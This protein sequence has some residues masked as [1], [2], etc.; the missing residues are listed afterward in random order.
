MSEENIRRRVVTSLR[1]AIDFEQQSN[2]VEAYRNYLEGLALVAAALQQDAD[3]CWTQGNPILTAKERKSLV[4]FA[5]QSVSRLVLLLDKQDQESSNVFKETSQ[6]TDNEGAMRSH[7]HDLPAVVTPVPS[8]QRGNAAR[9]EACGACEESPIAR[10]RHEN[11]LLVARY[12][13][14]LRAATTASQ[15]QNLQ[16]E[17][18]RRL[19]ENTAI[20]RQRQETWEQHRSE[21]A[22]RC[23]RLAESKFQIN[24]K[25]ESGTITEADFKKQRVYSAAL[26][27]EE[28]N[29]WFKKLKQDVLF[30][31][32]DERLQRDVIG[33]ILDRSHPVG[34]M[35][36]QMQYAVLD[37]VNPIITK[38]QS[39]LA[40][41]HRSETDYAL[42]EHKAFRRHFQNIAADIKRD[43]KLLETL[44]ITIVEPLGSDRGRGIIT[45][46]LHQVY[47]APVKHHLIILL[48]LVTHNDEVELEAAISGQAVDADAD[49]R[50]ACA[51]LRHLP[52][53][54]SPCHM[55]DSL[56]TTLKAL[57]S[58]SDE[59]N[60]CKS[61]GADDLLP[62]LTAVVILCRVPSLLAEA[63][64]MENFMPTERA[65]GEGGYAVTVLQSVMSCLLPHSG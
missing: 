4:G 23:H 60:H 13:T 40:Q 43:I 3:S 56:V 2:D 59:N 44:L 62:R 9:E 42:E 64:Y 19:S 14:R 27:F 8:P 21:V 52:S 12:S 65:L 22:A 31:P 57:A 53:L 34:A 18:E 36:C 41:R 61:L 37:K 58:T 5:E 1:K 30:Q 15:R 39:L 26:Q 45:E 33:R 63:T 6:V 29:S 48:R 11:K 25:I 54:H 32:H 7:C 51:M 55:L 24:E 16:L 20:A 50:Q 17:L 47:F 35:L 28:E 10:M 38:H 49:T 46:M